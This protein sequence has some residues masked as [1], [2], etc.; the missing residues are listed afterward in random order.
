MLNRVC[1]LKRRVA[2][3]SDQ[4]PVSSGPP[5]LQLAWSSLKR[6]TSR[7]YWACSLAA[8]SSERSSTQS[9][10]YGFHPFFTQNPKF[11][12][13]N[14]PNS[15]Q[16]MF[17]GLYTLKDIQRYTKLEIKTSF[18]HNSTIQPN[19]TKLSTTTTT[20]HI[21]NPQLWIPNALIHQQHIPRQQQQHLIMKSFTI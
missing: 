17:T 4:L 10:S 14:H 20:I 11:W 18:H 7:N 8:H 21:T 2:R 15:S 5:R 16:K 13:S 12:S 6:P 1:S 9:K 19:F 3:L